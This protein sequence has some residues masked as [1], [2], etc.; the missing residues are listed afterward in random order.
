MG[1]LAAAGDAIARAAHVNKIDGL[2]FM[3]TRSSGPFERRR[4]AW[5]VWLRAVLPVFAK[6]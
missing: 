1:Q 2:S 6:V 5:V 4:S 3:D